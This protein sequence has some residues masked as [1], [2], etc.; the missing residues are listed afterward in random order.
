M[1]NI[2]GAANWMPAWWFTMVG[3]NI[4]NFSV[5]IFLLFKSFKWEQQDP[6]DKKYYLF[7]RIF[8]LT[9]ALV[10]LYRS[11]FVS[12]YPNRLAWFDTL[13]NSPFIVRSL[14][15]FAEMS[16][17]GIIAVI[18]FRLNREMAVNKSGI[19]AKS[20]YIAVICI[21]VAQFFAFAG[22]ITQYNIW[23]AI[24]EGLWGLA[25]LSITPLVF[26]YLTKAKKQNNIGKNYKIALII[27]AVWCVGYGIF[28]WFYAM[29][30]IYIADIAHDV[31]RIIPPDA[32]RQSIFNYTAIRDFDTWGGIGFFIWHSG[33]FSICVWMVLF[34]MSIGRKR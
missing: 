16:F 18:L 26:A 2:L 20:P 33:Y 5:A 6:N 23:F 15:T 11:M 30:F 17:I 9:F 29:P 10:A 24:E 3:I 22:L 4:V 25:F 34:F 8:G 13:F 14:A 1:D 19:L 7:L 31:G 21:F 32:L 27:M 28:Q 12:S